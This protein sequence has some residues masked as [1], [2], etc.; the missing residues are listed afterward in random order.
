[1]E[2]ERIWAQVPDTPLEFF[3]AVEILFE[4]EASMWLDSNPRLE[5]FIENR[6]STTEENVESFKRALCEKFRSHAVELQKKRG[7]THQEINKLA[8]GERET[9]EDY[10]KRAQDLLWRAHGKDVPLPG[11]PALTPLESELLSNLV[12]NVVSGMRGP[13]IRRG[14]SRSGTR[15]MSRSRPGTGTTAGREQEQDVG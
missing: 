1:M 10:H 7:N 14:I 12:Y 11:E 2:Y 3:R 8:Q 5:L 13:E 9:L 4:G 15:S 6:S